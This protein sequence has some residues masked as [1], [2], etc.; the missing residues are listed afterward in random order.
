MGFFLYKVQYKTGIE[1]L[2]FVPI[3]D[4]GFEYVSR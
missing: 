2:P 3:D 1:I 4:S